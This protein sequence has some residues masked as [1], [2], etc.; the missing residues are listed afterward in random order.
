MTQSRLCP[1]GFFR[2]FVLLALVF[3]FGTAFTHQASAADP[4]SEPLKI[5]VTS[6]PP[7]TAPA[8]DGYLDKILKELFARSG[9]DC[10]LIPT[11]PRRG[12][13]DAD[14]G[15]LD[16]AVIPFRSLKFPR[17]GPDFSN[18]RVL[19]EPLLT[20]ELSGMYTRSNMVVTS[21]EDFFDYRLAFMRGWR[22]AEELFKEH[23]R[24]QKVSDPRLLM[25]MLAS[26]RVDIVFF[27]TVPGKYIARQI[28]L[29]NLKV[30]EFYIKRHLYL[31]LHK[32]HASLLPLLVKQL[33]AMKEDGTMKSIL[34]GYNVSR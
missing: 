5:A 27:S 19:P 11:P 25:E 31:H 14:A 2:V 21:V 1:D 12:L 26:D 22:Q 29:Q 18:L 13:T 28:G 34:A 30:S 33:V 17:K 8:G 15:I 7:V 4:N 16:A 23:E 24:T 32:R 3:V 9:I 10:E 6:L 20:T